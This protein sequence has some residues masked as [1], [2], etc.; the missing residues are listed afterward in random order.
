LT[1]LEVRN[2]YTEHFK[3]DGS[4]RYP[5]R[6]HVFVVIS[7]RLHNLFREARTPEFT[8]DRVNTGLIDDQGISYR[9]TSWDVATSRDD[10]FQRLNTPVLPEASAEGALVFAIPKD[11]TPSQ[12]RF[13]IRTYPMTADPDDIVILLPFPP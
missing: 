7:F 11:R 8:N 4:K 5:D 3:K 10:M 12:L 13:A 6:D 2:D 1:S 9:A